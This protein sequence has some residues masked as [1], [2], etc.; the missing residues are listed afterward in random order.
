MQLEKHIFM[1]FQTYVSYVIGIHNSS[2]HFRKIP[3]SDGI[4]VLQGGIVSPRH[5]K[6]KYLCGKMNFIKI[7]PCIANMNKQV[8]RLLHVEFALLHI[9]AERIVHVNGC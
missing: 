7:K 2:Q 3:T 4:Y 1:S 5:L 9:T 6:H 8:I